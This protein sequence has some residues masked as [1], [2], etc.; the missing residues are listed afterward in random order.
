MIVGRLFWLFWVL[1]LVQCYGQAVLIPDAAFSGIAVEKPWLHQLRNPPPR[2]SSPVELPADPLRWQPVES[3]NYGRGPFIG[4]ARFSVRSQQSR[5][6]WLELT[7]HFM[8]SVGVWVARPGTRP[9][10]LRGPTSHREQ[11]TSLAPV[12]H[13]YFLYALTLP[14]NQHVTV[15]IRGRVVPGDALKF[16]VRLWE[17]TRFL[18]IQ[19]VDLW[20]WAIFVGVVLAI[21]GGVLV[22]FL[23]YRRAIYLL[24]GTY[25]GCLSVYTLLNDGWGAFLPDSLAWFDGYSTIIHWLTLGFGAFVAFSRAFLRVKPGRSQWFV[26]VPLSV[27]ISAVRLSEWQP[28]HQHETLV[29]WLFLLGYTGF[30]SYGLLWTGYVLDAVR[31]RYAPVWLLLL[32]IS[33]V[34]AFF[35]VNTFLVNFGLVQTPLPDMLAMRLALLLE[36][37]ILSIGWLYQRKV[38]HTARRR[39]EDQN[40]ALQTDI[41][42]A[43]ETEQQRI[44]QDLHDD[45]GGTLATIRHQLADLHRH[46]AD[47]ATRQTLTNL[48]PLILKSGHDLRRIAHNLMPPD[49]DRLGL[50]ASLEQLIGNMPIRPTRFAFL[51]TGPAHRLPPDVELNAYRIVSELVQNVIK[52]AQAGRASVQLFYHADHLAVQVE[53]DGIGI[54]SDDLANGTGS[55]VSG[56]GM[57]LRTSK[58]RADY[59]GAALRQETGAGGTFILLEIPYSTADGQRFTL[60]NPPR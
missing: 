58:L 32:A 39:L 30:A 7:T 13:H 9:L 54:A 53:D 12:R 14:E 3:I 38:L 56:R 33:S 18:A 23:F 26:L 51:T 20:G 15:W 37:A 34:L 19:Q 21:L 43:Q 46:T 22:S 27:I 36:L 17:P 59:I 44:A 29:R 5:T 57:G 31:R 40:R 42:R 60:Q 55:F 35:L 24:Y 52:H 6:V 49:F 48:E 25:A 41:I 11:A 8:D 2:L 50:A 10:R 1:P 28:V 45:L 47:P 4:W 16:G